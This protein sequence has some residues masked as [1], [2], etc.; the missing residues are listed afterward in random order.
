MQ[1]CVVPPR[2]KACAS[3]VTLAFPGQGYDR[4]RVSV[5][6]PA[7]STVDAIVPRN[8]GPL[9]YG[10]YLA[11]S[12]DGGRTFA[13]ADPDLERFAEQAVP[14]P[15]AASRWSVGP[16][17]SASTPRRRTARRGAATALS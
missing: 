4:S 9:D 2:A 8:V 11:R 7:P 13:P 17:A 12:V 3:V 1:F 16:A 15:P 14:G 6:L 10:T 5:L